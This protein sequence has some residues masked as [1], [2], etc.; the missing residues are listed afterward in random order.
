MKIIGLTGSIGMGKSATAKLLRVLKVPVF[1]SDVCVHRLIQTTA[2]PQI[3]KAFSSVWDRKTQS[4][5]RKA[6]GRIVF[7]S[8]VAKE[9]LENILH[10]L[11][12][13]EQQ[14]FIAKCRRAGHRAIVL[15]VPLL[16]E[17]GRNRICDKTICVTAPSF[18]QKTRVL[19]RKGMSS[20]KYQAVLKAQMPDRDKRYLSD[21]VVQTGLGR[22]FTLQKLKKIL[23]SKL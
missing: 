4:I 9:E 1:D 18:I 17:T 23:G 21:F 16:F 6:L 5:D 20:E 8:P 22:A 2:V 11:V 13:E 12:W 19:S 10:P 3:R 15:D 7:A 14:K